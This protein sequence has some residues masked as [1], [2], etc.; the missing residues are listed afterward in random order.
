MQALAAPGE[1]A[2]H[3]AAE[4][5]G[6]E[7]LDLAVARGEQR[8]PNTLVGDF[9]LLDHGKAQDVAIESIRVGQPLHHDPDMM[10][11]SYHGEPSS[12]AGPR[13]DRSTRWRWGGRGPRVR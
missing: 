8:R 4:V 10:N 12:V 3:P 2:P 1:E 13:A 6:F 5:E 9:G 7:Q 11:A